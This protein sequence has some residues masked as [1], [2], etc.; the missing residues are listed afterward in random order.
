VGLCV[1][2]SVEMVVGLLGILKAGGAYVPLDPTYPRTRVEYMLADAQVQ[3]VLTQG[4][5]AERMTRTEARVVLLDEHWEEIAGESKEN[6]EPLASSENLAYIVYTSGSTGTPKGVA[7]PHLSLF[8][9]LAW[10]TNDFSDES[11]DRTLQFASVNFDV[12]FQEI[13]A[14]LS[15]G[16]PLVMVTEE[17]RRDPVQL[18]AG[19]SASSVQRLFIPYVGLQQLAVAAIGLQSLPAT[20]RQVITAGEQLHVTSQ[21]RSLFTRL[22]KCALHNQYGPSEAHVVTE[23]ILTDLP[24]QWDSSPP[25]G[26][27]IANTEV[28]LLDQELRP[29]P[30]GVT[31]EL[32]IGGVALARG[33]LGRPELT[34]ERFIPHPHSRQP[35]RRLYRTGDLARYRADGNIEFLGRIDHQVK[36]RGFRIELGEIEAVLESHAAVRQAVVTVHEGQWLVGYVVG[37][38]GESW[39][40]S[41]REMAAELRPY[42]RERLPEYMVPQ[43]WVVLEQ[44]PVTANGKLDRRRLPAPSGAGPLEQEAASEWTPVEELLVGIWSEV[45]KRGAVGRNENFFELGGHSLLATQVISRVRQVFGVEVG[46]RRSFEEPTVRGLS[47]CI[48]EQLRAGAGVTVPLLRRAGVEGPGRGSRLLPLSFAQQRLWFLD[49][50]EPGSASYNLPLAVRLKGELRLAVLERTLSEIVRRHEVLRTR[51][52]NVG[53]EPRQE[54]LPAEPLAL[55]VIDLS[56]LGAAEREAVMRAAVSAENREPLDLETG[57]MLRVK[58]LRLGAEEHVVLLTMH[59]IVSDGWSLGVLIKEV[60]TLYETY[61]RDAE[62]TLPELAIQYSDYAIW[63]RG[64]LQGEELERQ[65]GYWREQLGGE[66]PVLELPTDH[67]R[68]AL[69]SYRGAHLGFRLSA[70]VSAGLKELSR[71][72]GVTLFMTLLAAYQTLLHRYSGQED[73]VVGSAVAG[74]NYAETEGLIGFFVNT[75]A[76]R[77]DLSGEPTFV[78]LLGRVKQV[79]LG[80]YGHQDVPFEKLVE[81]LQPERDP[82]RTPLFQTMF[83]MQNVP[84]TELQLSGLKL[85]RVGGE[86][87]TAKFDLLLGLQERGEGVEGSFEYSTDLFERERIERLVRHFE[88]LLQGIVENPEQ[89]LWELPLLRAEEEQ[90]A[91]VEWNATQREYPRETSVSELFER[92]VALRPAA[93][94]VVSGAEQLSYAE[95]NERANQLAHYL[96]AL[97]VAEEECVGVCLGRGVELVIALLGVLKAGGVYVPLDPDYPASRL[98]VMLAD[99]AVRVLITKEMLSAHLG[100][101]GGRTLYLDREEE[102]LRSGSSGNLASSGG[103]ERLA[104]VMYT[105]GSTGQPKG[106]GIPHRAINRLVL[107]TDY[108]QLGPKDRVAQVSTVSFDAATFEI[109]GALLNGARLVVVEKEVALSALEFG[110]ALREQE[111]NTLFLTTALFNRLVQEAGGEVFSGLKQLLFG[112]EAVDTHWVSA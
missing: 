100:E 39:L 112:G 10:Q 104:Y 17:D 55:P 92:Q 65:L 78:E 42:L 98:Q 68:P 89:R 45:L 23:A 91:L 77:T 74:R 31:G 20:L 53:G 70:E 15:S 50:L 80:A 58:L 76:L 82:S 34:A 1:E 93:V 110:Q 11:A 14:T 7:M 8:N 108:V 87:A 73:I 30:V 97:G 101:Y 95:L 13:F 24:S 21:I 48:E 96:K 44:I 81:E 9:M 103:G 86:S 51:F 106:I 71:R 111:I 32:Y 47:S 29:V 107:N 69:P 27:P 18:L 94:A 41:E 19:L 56:E 88:V 61:S 85:G 2:R 59:H 105:S 25:I 90:Q 66:L 4:K 57:P 49:Q 83:A 62:A 33:Y 54:V 37:A 36:L 26:K 6:P 64:W 3:L 67:A 28:Y 84:E 102:Q 99:A 38:E 63:Q 109:W 12:S 79:C 60:A 16:G 40:G 43:R 52:V 5:L 22:E 75:L 46:L 72:E 35:G